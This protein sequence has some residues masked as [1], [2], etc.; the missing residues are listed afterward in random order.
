MAWPCHWRMPYAEGCVSARSFSIAASANVAIARWKRW[1]EKRSALAR[2]ASG[3]M[4]YGGR[5]ETKFEYGCKLVAALS[6]LMLGQTESVGIGLI[7]P[8]LDQW[9][10]PRAGSGCRRAE[11]CAIG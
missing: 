1:V 11:P 3:S 8:R 10:A 7:G 6:Y 2:H 9:V 5:A 4:A